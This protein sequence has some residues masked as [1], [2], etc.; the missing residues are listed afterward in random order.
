MQPARSR[1]TI[2]IFLAADFLY[3]ASMYLYVPTLPGI[4]EARTGSLAAVGIVISMYGLWQAVARIPV[5]VAVDATGRSRIFLAGGFVLSAAGAVVMCFGRTTLALAAGRALTGL[6]AATWV[7]LVTVFG[8]F[9]PPERLLAATSLLN[10]VGAAGRLSGLFAGGLTSDAGGAAV[11]FVLAAASGLLAL[12]ALGGI[13][14]PRAVPRPPSLA[15]FLTLAR[16]RD[17]LV[18][19]V[20]QT[21]ASFANWAVTMTF[22]PVLAGRLGA[23]GTLKG[24]LM[25]IGVAAGLAGSALAGPA[26]RRFGSVLTLRAVFIAYCGGIVGAALSPSLAPLFLFATLMGFANGF[27]Y[28]MLMGLAVRD[29]DVEERATATGIHQAVYATG[30]FAGPSVAGLV[31][32]RLGIRAMFVLTAAL[33]LSVV[34]PLLHVLAGLRRRAAP[35]ALH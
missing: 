20:A 3:W 4:I 17:V 35:A 10:M 6:A 11:P 18:P 30:M 31:A 2:L 23:G 8:G 34:L 27:Y 26:E 5:G 21:F 7:P 15:R 19:T 22:L 12:A 1:R 29:V 33:T 25:S 13:Q 16:R 28:P 32:E 24:M 9:F 14:V